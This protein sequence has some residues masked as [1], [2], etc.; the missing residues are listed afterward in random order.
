MSFYKDRY[1]SIESLKEIGAKQVVDAA[2]VVDGRLNVHDD[3]EIVAID[4]ERGT[5]VAKLINDRGCPYRIVI[6]HD[7]RNWEDK[8]GNFGTIRSYL[9][10]YDLND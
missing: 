6:Y 1:P 7:Y 10:F 9:E 5:I 4:E 8:V 2:L 3:M